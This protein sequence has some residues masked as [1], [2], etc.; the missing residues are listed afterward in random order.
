MSKTEILFITGN[1][2]SSEELSKQFMKY[3][4]LNIISQGNKHSYKDFK[5]F[6][7]LLKADKILIESIKPNGLSVMFWIFTFLI[8]KLLNKK[9]LLHW[10]GTD[11]TQ[12]SRLT[13]VFLS[14]LL[15]CQV[16]QV[17]W[18]CEELKAKGINVREVS[19]PPSVI[20]EKIPS[21]P[22]IFTVLIYLGNSKGKELVYSKE[23][24][25]KLVRKFKDIRFYIVGGNNL[26]VNLSNV[27]NLGWVFPS[28]MS[29]IYSE[30][31]VLLRLTEHDGLS[32]MVLEA[33]GRGRYVIWSQKYPHCLYADNLLGISV[34]LKKLSVSKLK[35]NGDGQQYVEKCFG[36]E[37]VKK[38]IGIY[39]K[40]LRRN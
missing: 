15:T 27:H 16:A 36:P 40:L 22:K 39:E 35:F 26:E 37:S 10:Q 11:V 20:S 9:V 38:T 29:E 25:E 13:G 3:S 21:L 30:T 24:M 32:H 33:L 6:R 34:L 8:L 28:K 4:D 17:S 7:N 1:N 5:F 19:I 2:L 31:T 23:E 14:K 18:L 12:V